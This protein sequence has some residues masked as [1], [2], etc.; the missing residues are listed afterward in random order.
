MYIRLACTDGVVG[1]APGQRIAPQAV[2]RVAVAT[3]VVSGT[4]L[5]EAPLLRTIIKQSPA[6]RWQRTLAIGFLAW[7]LLGAYACFQQIELRTRRASPPL[8]YEEAIYAHLPFIYD[9]LFV[10]AEITGL[11]GAVLFISR[12]RSARAWFV[13]SLLFIT[14]QFGYLFAATELLARQGPGALLFPLLVF[15]IGVT[16]MWAASAN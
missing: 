4:C 2:V 10:G 5:L 9:C 13:A 6:R 3:C 11:I 1:A 16:Q 8:R 7:N 14:L 15:A 12:K